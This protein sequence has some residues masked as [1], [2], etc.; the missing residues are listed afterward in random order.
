MA[1]FKALNPLLSWVN[2]LI[3]VMNRESITIPEDFHSQ[4]IE[5]KEN[6]MSDVS[7]LVNS[8]LDFAISSASVDY[9]VE[10]GNENL[11]KIFNEWTRKINSEWRGLVP[12]GIKALA[13]E[14]FRERWK[15]SSLCI[16]RTV[17]EKVNGFYLPTKMWFVDGGNVYVKSDDEIATIDGKQYYLKVREDKTIKLPKTKNEMIFVQKPFESWGS[18]YPTPFLVR[19]GILRNIKFLDLLS[20]KGEEVVAKALEYLLLFKKGTEN[21]TLQKVAVYDGKDFKNLKE[22]FKKFVDEKKAN[23]GVPTYFTG[24]DTE[25]EHLIPDY[26]K[27]VAQSLYSPIERRILAGLGL[28]EIIEG[29][30]TTRR[31]ALLNPKPF[32]KE[33]RQAVEDFKN[34]LMDLLEEIK[35][36]NSDDHKKYTSEMIKIY[37]TPIPD[38]ISAEVRDHFRRMYERGVLSK[39]TYSEVCGDGVIDYDLEV[40]RRKKEAIKGEEILMYPPAIQNR[41][42]DISPTE[43]KRLE[44]IPEDKQEPDNQDYVASKELEMAPYK[45]VEDLPKQVRNSLSPKLQKV[46]LRVVN[47]ALDRYGDDTTAFKIA[48]DVIKRISK[49][50][51]NGK[52]V[53]KKRVKSAGKMK[54]IEKATIDEIITNLLDSEEIEKKEMGERNG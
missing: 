38:F 21:L 3:E 19:R 30:T 23:A 22:E 46:F 25:L 9:T 12:T 11:T 52:W 32:I 35:E 8:I 54:T 26:S 37:T 29:T 6:L 10:T 49:R 27:A 43:E 41:E 36:R 45:K 24:F 5:I 1:T 2:K 53:M 40:Q 42:A 31:E 4:V 34:L 16:L 47:Q 13:K 18:D 48:W 15:G 7:G 17:W 14:Y 39:R 50:D 20:Q 33:V 28:V 44:E 51:K